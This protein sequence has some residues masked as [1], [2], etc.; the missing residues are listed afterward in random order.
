MA[1]LPAKNPLTNALDQR[2]RSVVSETMGEAIRTSIRQI[3]QEELASAL[4]SSPTPVAAAPARTP[5]GAR[6]GLQRAARKAAVKLCN[7]AGCHRPHRSQGYCAAHYQS[8]RKYGWPMPAPK[9]FKLPGT[10][11]RGRPTKAAAAPGK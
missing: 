11:R 3:I 6:V 9:G 7:V 4:G 10:A 2:I 8:A 1:R 5:K